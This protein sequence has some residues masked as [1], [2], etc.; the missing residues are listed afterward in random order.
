MGWLTD[1][2]R[3]ELIA[4]AGIE[5]ILI[6]LLGGAL[7]VVVV[8]RGLPYTVEAFG[9][10][11]FPGA[12]VA[13]AAGGSIVAGG[14]IAGLVAAVAIAVATRSARTSDETA[15]GV[16]FTG[17]FAL[18]V[19]LVSALGPLTQD[20]SSFLFGSLLGVSAADLAVSAAIT[21]AV[22]GVLA[23]VRRPL[24][25]RAFDVD[26]AAAAGV[27][28]GILDVAVLCLLALAVVA[29]IRAVGTVLV[30][31]LFV[32]PAAAARLLA[33]RVATTVWCAIAFG[34]ASGV[35]GL[36]ISY[37]A[38]VAAGGAVV[39]SATGIFALTLLVSPRSGLVAWFRRVRAAQPAP[40]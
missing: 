3:T 9:H 11:V 39:L 4:R 40:H 35:I 6:G 14:A 13:A 8:L 12:V 21:V 20:V 22:I 37:H 24:M 5:L 27:R 25:A 18:G 1:P 31:A 19:L 7:G 36:Y 23:A 28:V 17:M 34:A 30:L 33:R 32:T 15:V 16:V 10:T 2:W 29:S 38:G 26:A